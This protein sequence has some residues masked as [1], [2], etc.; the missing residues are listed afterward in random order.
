MSEMGDD[1]KALKEFQRQN[2]EI[3]R[4]KETP[5]ILALTAHGF[6]VEQLTP[7][8][9]RVNRVLD[10][11]PT[12]RKYHYLPTQERGRYNDADLEKLVKAK[13]GLK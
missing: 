3:R 10:L 4:N 12:N 7:F 8:H 6:T 5:K 2:K 1:F 9:F 11:F 13:L